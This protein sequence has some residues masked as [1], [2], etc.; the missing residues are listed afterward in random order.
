MS[1]ESCV[2]DCR[3]ISS[4]VPVFENVGE[5]S[6]ARNCR[7]VSVSLL[8]TVSKVS[9]KLANNRILDHL[10]KCGFFS[11]FQHGFRSSRSTADLL[12]VLSD[13]IAMAFNSSGAT[14]VLQHLI[15]PRLLTEFGML[16]F[17]T[18]LSL[19]EFQVR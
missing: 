18:N 15:Y 13:K 11:Y 6:T 12:T 2:Q 19:V 9:E 17:F 7:P 14:R 8:C 5:R 4:V 3:K 1:K 16:V 10:E